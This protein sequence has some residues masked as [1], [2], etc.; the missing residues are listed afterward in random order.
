MSY[1]HAFLS[2]YGNRYAKKRGSVDT[3]YKTF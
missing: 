3:D 2:Q 1:N